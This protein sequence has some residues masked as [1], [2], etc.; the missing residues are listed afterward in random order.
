MKFRNFQGKSESISEMDHQHISNII[1]YNRI[2][3][4]D[5]SQLRMFSDELNARF[6]GE[7]LPYNPHH[8]FKNEIKWLNDNE[9]FVWNKEKTRADIII[10]DFE[11]N[12]TKII[13]FY[14]TTEFIRDKKIE[15]ILK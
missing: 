10:Y 9:H 3:I 13:G 6:N 5:R 4:K 7:L 14:E 11:S 15:E 12:G 8:K 2:I 1:W